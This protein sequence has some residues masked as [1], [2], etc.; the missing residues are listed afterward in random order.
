MA[1]GVGCYF[2]GKGW[3]DWRVEVGVVTEALL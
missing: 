3:R 2:V 1:S